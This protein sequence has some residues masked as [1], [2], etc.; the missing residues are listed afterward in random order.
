MYQNF[1]PLAESFFDEVQSRINHLWCKE[2]RVVGVY[3]VKDE[4]MATPGNQ[5][6][7]VILGGTS[8][9]IA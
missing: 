8:P 9:S 5:V 7:W 4:A 1:L 3:D 6:L 2:S